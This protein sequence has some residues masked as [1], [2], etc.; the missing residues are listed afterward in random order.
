MASGNQS[1]YAAPPWLR[2]LGFASWLLVGFVLVLVGVTWL[3]AETSTITMPVIVAG[4]IGSVCGPIVGRLETKG[5]PRAAGAALVL[6]GLVAIGVGIFV[7]VVTGISSQS[8]EI[9][10][11]ANGGLDKLQDW[12]ASLGADQTEAAKKSLQD[13]LPEIR[14]TLVGGVAHTIEGLGSL[15]F[16]LSFALLATFFVLKD[17]PV[18]KAF[19]NRHLGLP[20]ATAE[21]VTSRI[22][23][24]FRHYFGGLT[25]IAAFNG[26]VVGLG[27]WILGVPLA[28]TIAVVTFVTAY[29]PIVGAWVA[30]IFA[31]LLALGSQGASDAFILALIILLANGALQNILQ[32]FVFGATLQLNP[33]AVL[34]VT[35]GAGCLFGL[36]GMTLAAPLTS[37]AVHISNELRA[38]PAATESPP[39]P[40]TEEAPWVV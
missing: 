37:A 28:G 39:P 38:E 26:A 19:I 10:S 24:S 11:N 2:N 32:P 21:I 36:V 30:G 29:V 35:I 17:A 12:V 40:P 25:I 1:L 16:F 8:A 13:A 7:L 34:V 22:A 4:V 14:Q 5:V 27:A 3:V 6:L 9:S 18:M 15:A 23:D 20:A 31:F 33:L